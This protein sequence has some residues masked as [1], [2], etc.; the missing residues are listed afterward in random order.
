[1]AECVLKKEIRDNTALRDCFCLLQHIILFINKNK[2]AEQVTSDS[3]DT[4]LHIVARYALRTYNI[5]LT[6]KVNI[7]E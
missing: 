6:T 7:V 2:A 4:P 5:Y 1:M 3:L